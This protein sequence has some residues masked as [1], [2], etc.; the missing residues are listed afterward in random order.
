[1]KI[2]LATIFQ[3][4]RSKLESKEPNQNGVQNR[5]IFVATSYNEATAIPLGNLILLEADDKLIR[6]YTLDSISPIPFNSPGLKNFY[7]DNLYLLRSF[8]H[9][10][11]KYVI[12]LPMVTQIKDNHVILPR[13]VKKGESPFF[14]IP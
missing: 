12:N 5:S 4:Q 7:R 13:E 10:N 11:R 14:R 2:E 8:H 9:L 3:L 6:A 1:D